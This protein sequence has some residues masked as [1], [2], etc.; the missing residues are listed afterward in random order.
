MAVGAG[1]PEVRDRVQFV[2][3]PDLAERTEMVDVNE[4]LPEIAVYRLE[5]QP[6]DGARCPVVLK[7]TSPS[8]RVAFVR[9]DADL[10]LRTLQDTCRPRAPLRAGARVGAE[11]GNPQSRICTAC[12]NV[13]RFC[14]GSGLAVTT[15]PTEKR[16]S[17]W[18]GSTCHADGSVEPKRSASVAT[19]ARRLPCT[20]R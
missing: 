10:L 18:V 14:H 2:L 19:V 3:L 12:W 4:T 17:S 8:R 11:Q 6:A 5:V 16:I 13:G 9:V 7:A 20:T 15:P 1:W